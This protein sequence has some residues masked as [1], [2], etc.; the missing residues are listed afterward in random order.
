MPSRTRNSSPPGCAARGVAVT[1]GASAS[2]PTRLA[3]AAAATA[4]RLDS[5][6]STYVFHAPQPGQR[7]SHFGLVCPQ[8]W[9]RN[10][11]FGLDA[12]CVGDMPRMLN[13]RQVPCKR[14]TSALPH[15]SLIV[16]IPPPQ[17]T[18]AACAVPN[19]RSSELPSV[20]PDKVQEV[21]GR[22]PSSPGNPRTKKRGKQM[23]P[24]LFIYPSVAYCVLVTSITG[25]ILNSS[26]S[27]L[28]S[29]ITVSPGLYVP[30]RTAS[31]SESSMFFSMTLR[32]GRAPN[33]GS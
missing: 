3:A 9:Q 11:I 6:N 14:Q 15:P 16:S 29:T 33:V 7:P 32:S 18:I 22:A 10:V 4:G 24:P 13:H 20:L 17:P 30:L 31:D 21:R 28:T 26:S 25:P 19:P 27:V 8:S 5:L 2:P 23:L 12:F 1:G